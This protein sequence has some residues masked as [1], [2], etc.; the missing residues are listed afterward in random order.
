MS[1]NRVSSRGELEQILLS[2]QGVVCVE[3]G[4]GVELAG[5]LLRTASALSAAGGRVLIV[6]ADESVVERYRV[7]L[8]EF[9]GLSMK[10]VASVRS[11]CLRILESAR[12]R[13]LDVRG[14]RVLNENEFDVLLEDLKTCGVRPWRLREM[15]KFLLRGVSECADEQAEWL[16]T[17]EERGVFDLLRRHLAAR[18]AALPCELPSLAYWCLEQA[19]LLCG[20]HVVI[21]DDFGAL[22]KAAQR[23]VARIACGRL[24]A[25]GSEA[26]VSLSSEEPYPH[27]EGFVALREAVRAEAE[28]EDGVG[29]QDRAYPN[30]TRVVFDEGRVPAAESRVV[31]DD[32]ATEIA[33][34]AREVAECCGAGAVGRVGGLWPRDILVAAPSVTWG[35][36]LVAAL[37]ERGVTA[38]LDEGRPKI[39]G[40]PRC[41]ESCGD[42]RLAAFAQLFFEPDD[43]VALRSWLGYGDWLLRS[44]A[45]MDVMEYAQERGLGVMKALGELRGRAPEERP[46]TFAKLLGPLEELDELRKACAEL[47]CADAVALLAEHGMKLNE[48]GMCHGDVSADT[49]LQECV[50][51]YVPMTHSTDAGAVVVAPYIR[52]C[53]R[54]A[55][56]TFIAGLVNGFLPALDAVDDGFTIE[57]RRRALARQRTLFEAVRATAGEAVVYSRFECARLVEAETQKMQVTRVFLRNRERFARVAPS[58]FI[59]W[60]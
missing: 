37:G 28:S 27:A 23:L 49:F 22:S 54:R 42:L 8:E 13:G 47:S 15:L 14:A 26:G 57:H 2:K 5:S 55:R 44:D 12:V 51:R 9:P 29:E 40:N 35:A 36:Q 56:V 11:V 3:R 38:M 31:Y 19:V 39:K 41:I 48:D 30:V 46:A 50:S 20:P 7:R 6:C 60:D 21:A 45:F 34:I 52:A 58:G 24:I 18:R 25:C 53:S 17:A 4:L 59:D 10:N 43:V 32:S 16:M 1:V 33:E